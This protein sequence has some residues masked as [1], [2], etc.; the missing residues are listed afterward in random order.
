[1]FIRWLILLPLSFLYGLIVAFRN[2]LFDYKILKTTEFDLPII[3]VGNITVGGTGKT[4][5][6]EY[7]VELLKDQYKIFTLSRGYKRK[8]SGYFCATNLSSVKEI[9]DEPKQIKQKFPDIEVAVCANRVK[10]IKKIMQQKVEVILLDDAYQHRYVKPGLSILLVD[11]NRPLHEDKILP[12]GMLRESFGELKRADIVVITKTP[13]EIKPIERRLLR[14][15]LNV[16]PFQELYFTNFQYGNLIPIPRFHNQPPV[17]LCLTEEFA[18]KKT[19]ILLVTGISSPQPLIEHLRQYA[20]EIE[21]LIFADHHYYSGRNLLE[22]NHKFEKFVKNN[23]GSESI[24]VTTEKDAIRLSELPELI[25]G[26][27][28]FIP[29][30]YIPVKVEFLSDKEQFD[31]QI[32]DYVVNYKRKRNLSAK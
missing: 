29:I 3:S 4:P 25:Y 20:G 19:N 28:I 14:N 16:L 7:L 8:S 10:G 30:Y 18:E 27:K 17:E 6:I 15:N 31:N 21:H 26:K 13:A 22:I 9:G 24:L 2:K 5:H 32:I 23:G 1:M 11:F 12:L